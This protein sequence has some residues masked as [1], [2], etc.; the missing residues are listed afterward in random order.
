MATAKPPRSLPN[1]WRSSAGLLLGVQT[2]L[3]IRRRAGRR[4][5]VLHAPDLGPRFDEVVADELPGRGWAVREMPHVRAVWRRLHAR[6]VA[7]YAGDRTAE[8][9]PIW[10]LEHGGDH[11]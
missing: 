3:R 9:R 10:V 7:S 8:D 5:L 6:G 2:E 11:G 1:R 4:R